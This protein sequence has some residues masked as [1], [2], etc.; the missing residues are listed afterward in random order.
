MSVYCEIIKYGTLIQLMSQARLGSYQ[1]KKQC[2]IIIMY[3]TINFYVK[4]VVLRYVN[5]GASFL[6]ISCFFSLYIQK[7]LFRNIYFLVRTKSDVTPNKEPCLALV[8]C[9]V[10]LWC[11]WPDNMDH[12]SI[13][14]NKNKSAEL[15]V[16]CLHSFQ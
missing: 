11:R 16:C 13:R 12:I 5:E 4:E 10:L 9:V 2:R 8:Y 3:G 1:Y 6:Y 14:K 15:I 7:C